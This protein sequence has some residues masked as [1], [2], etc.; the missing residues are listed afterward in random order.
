[1]FSGGTLSCDLAIANVF[2]FM[3]ETTPMSDQ[4]YSV[5]RDIPIGIGASGERHEMNS[6]GGI[7]V[8]ADRAPPLPSW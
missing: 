2:Y 3:R 7:H 1:L 8:A 6:M 4:E 5:L